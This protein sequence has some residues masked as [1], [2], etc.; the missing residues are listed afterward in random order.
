MSDAIQNARRWLAAYDGLPENDKV[1]AVVMGAHHVRQLLVEMALMG[2][3]PAEAGYD[4]LMTNVDAQVSQAIEAGNSHNHHEE[5]IHLRV[6]GVRAQQAVAAAIWDGATSARAPREWDELTAKE[7]DAF[8]SVVMAV[9]N[10]SPGTLRSLP[11]YPDATAQEVIAECDHDGTVSTE[12]VCA[13]LVEAGPWDEIDGDGDDESLIVEHIRRLGKLTLSTGEVTQLQIERMIASVTSLRSSIPET[14]PTWT[15]EQLSQ[16]YDV[17]TDVLDDLTGWVGV[18]CK[19]GVELVDGVIDEMSP[20]TDGD[21]IRLV[22]TGEVMSRA[23]IVD[24]M[25]V[26]VHA[27]PRRDEPAAPA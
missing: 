4:W 10:S 18:K 5:D 2:R 13:A 6:A 9:L 19:H 16:F 8:Q 3:R 26:M 22:I 23:E 1:G 25:S 17:L 7:A 24:T 11:G 21:G 14:P 20:A 12:A 27:L 15:P